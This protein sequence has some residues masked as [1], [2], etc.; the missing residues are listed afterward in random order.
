MKEWTDDEYLLHVNAREGASLWEI[1]AD[2]TQSEDESLWETYIPVFSRLIVRWQ[3]LG[4]I[5]VYRGSEWPADIHGEEVPTDQVPDLVQDH[6]QLEVRG[7]ADHA[8]CG[9]GGRS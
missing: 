5:K 6:G 8:H 3:R 9:S 1:L 2:R 4:F 7:R